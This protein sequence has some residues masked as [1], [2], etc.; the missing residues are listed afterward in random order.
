M[1]FLESTLLFCFSRRL[2]AD[3]KVVKFGS[4]ATVQTTWYFV[5]TL[6]CPSIIRPDDENFPSEPSSVSRSFELFQLA[7]VQTSQQ[8]VRTPL[9]VQS[10]MGFLSKTQIW[11]DSCN[12]PDNVDSY[13][14]ALIYKASRPFKIQ[15]S[16]R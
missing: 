3:F 13:P 2:C 7:S 10:A 14:D 15:T 8:H 6:N 4:L 16:R 5:W 9:S 11:K 1:L 12:H